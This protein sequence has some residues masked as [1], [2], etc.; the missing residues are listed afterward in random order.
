MG[1]PS[2]PSPCDFCHEVDM[3]PCMYQG[4]EAKC[5]AFCDRVEYALTRVRAFAEGLKEEI[6]RE[7][8]ATKNM[9]VELNPLAIIDRALAE[10][11][12]GK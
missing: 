2:N 8:E 1:K 9:D 6:A 7:Q 11:E 12:E 3:D 10:Q 4:Y 5:P